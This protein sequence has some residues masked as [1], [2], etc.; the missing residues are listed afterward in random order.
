M[1]S[2]FSP[3]VLE[4]LG[5]NNKET[6][7]IEPIN[8]GLIK[9]PDQKDPNYWTIAQDM[10]LSVPQGIVNAVEEQGDFIDENIVPLGGLEF[11]DKDGKL[12]F[13][14]FIPKYV[15]PTKW[16]A[17]EYSKKRQLPI[18]HKPET[19][20]GNMT[21]GISRFLTGFAGPAK[22][23]KGAGLAGGAIKTSLRGF[24]AGAVADLTV[25]DPNEGRLSNMLVE[26][27]SPVLN[28]AVTQYLATDEN[29][30]EMEGRLKNVLEGMALGGIVESVFYG[31]KG[32]K[33]MKA[34]NNLDERA[35]IQ[36]EV[37]EVIK[38]T[39]EP[40]IKKL[41]ED[42]NIL[43][44]EKLLKNI[45]DFK[46]T[47][48]K[49]YFAV[50]SKTKQLTK[51]YSGIPA[52]KQEKYIIQTEY[53]KRL[54]AMTVSD[55]KI[56]KEFR[57]LGAGKALYKVAIK[58]AFDKGLDF[59]SDN[60]ISES[61]LRVYKSLEKE[62]FDV[63]YNKNVKTVK[64]EVNL[65][66]ERGKQ[67]ITKDITDPMP[68]I[69]IKRK[70]K[71]IK[72]KSKKVRKFALEGDN[73]INTEEAL[74]IITKSK[75]AAKRDSELWIKKIL[76]TKSFTSGEQV[77]TTIDNIVDNGLDDAT[78][79]FL[80][81]DVL[82]NETALELA[83][84]AGRNQKEVLESIMKEGVR[85]KEATVRMLTTKSVFQQLGLDYQKVSGKYLADF[86]EDVT[87]W[88]KK[89]TI[90]LARRQQVIQE[91]FISLKNQIRNPART[92]QAGRIKVPAADGK[93]INME[94][95]ANIF[96]DYNANPAVIAKKI[97][98]MKPEDIIN[99]LTKSKSAKAIEVF[100]SLYINS[101]L[102][103]TP[104]LIVNT[105]GNAYEAFLKPMEMMAGAA[106]RA[107]RK[108]FNYGFSHYIGMTFKFR[109]TIKS[110]GLALKQGDAVLDPLVRTQDNLQII[111][112]KAVRP[113]SGSNLGFSGKFGTA[114]DWIGGISEIPTRLLLTTDEF[115][116]QINYRGRL[117]AEA[118]DNTLELDFKLKSKEG[119]A[120]IEKIF[121][122]GFDKNG[123]ANVKDN[124]MATRALEHSR[125]GSFTNTLDDGRLLNIGK[126]VEKFLGEVPALRFLAPFVRT[127]TQ[128]WRN[129]EQRIPL[130]GAFT[131]PMRD[132][133]K[134]GDRRARADVIGRQ[135]FGLATTVYAYHLATQDVTDNKGNK[136]RKITGAG[137]KNYNVKKLWIQAG[138]QE[139]SIAEKNK[140]GTVTYKQ[141][142]RN[143]PRFYILGIMADIFENKDN[144]NDKDKQSMGWV[145]FISAMRSAGNKSYLRGVSDGFDLAE[146]LDSTTLPK[147]VG[148]QFA[149]A[150]PY[151]ALV[152]QGIPGI[153]E[154]DTE[155]LK[156]RTFVD[157][158]IKKTPFI[159]KTKYLE[160]VINL[161]TGEPVERS[162]S[163]VYFNAAGVISYITQGPFLVGRKS[164]VKEDNVTLELG[165]LKI[166]AIIEPSIKQHKIVNLINYKIDNQ[167]AHNYWIER[168]GK[169]TRR[170]LTFKEQLEKTFDS[171]RYQ[172][173]KEGNENFDGGKEMT[174]K[175]IFQVYTKQAEK[176]MLEKYPE[177]AEAYKNA[178]IEKY[179]FRKTTFDIDE[180]PKELLPRK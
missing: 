149:N 56:S 11:G 120:N 135:T 128:L 41:S 123:K 137:P 53:S 66:L 76:N 59:A 155:V 101:I 38:E 25:F 151:T 164:D 92:T 83:K 163:S 8:S 150:I 29:D 26:F 70:T 126:A 161:I 32:F 43:K 93:M 131:K 84:L 165:R 22:F 159:D 104:T 112:G 27:D 136:Y 177:V 175:K 21:E 124:V 171:I 170:G 110:I 169:T 37:S 19:M 109:D 79:E 2:E 172:R 148:K 130:F 15:S 31:I 30:T 65:D 153:I 102:S 98:D 114:I 139:Y 179:G 162:T 118:V 129:F 71:D 4:L 125:I 7:K 154:A 82:S 77:L 133:W 141:Y 74:K 134:S 3:Q 146:N 160:P 176:D 6:V 57:N 158:I 97:K 75:E 61:A 64:N 13:K 178:K 107:D 100:N 86:G 121:K 89:S 45:D 60:S 52:T 167:S 48:K 138:W 51:E 44:E 105:L 5:Q 28:N 33:K 166:K 12:S 40:K 115:F 140:D 63:V 152:G 108:T 69:I 88:S 24:G 132:M 80:E 111:N 55:V 116:K 50:A 145:A 68:V 47:S 42:I 18:F 106:L 157:E 119:I 1:S 78:K 49:D 174:I 58:N 62:G 20:A 90:D 14:D 36:K 173:R 180:K 54:N 143:D 72:L 91:V 95:I 9:K 127:P 144:I 117:Y 23:L 113:I 147:Y 73:A 85:D 96:K 99:E 34:T 168:I 156:A 87:K 46:I 39:Q 122:D 17:E 67:I 16:K 103:G 142:N 35:K 94:K 81:N 10:A